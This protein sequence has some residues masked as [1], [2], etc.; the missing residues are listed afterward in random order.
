VKDTLKKMYKGK[1]E[2]KAVSEMV[3]Y[4]ILISIAMGV[5]VGVYAMIRVY[6]NWINESINCKDG[7]SI[8]I[9]SHTCTPNPGGKIT[10]KIKNNGRFNVDG[11][12]VSVGNDSKKVP[13]TYLKPD[14]GTYGHHGFSPNL[15]PGESEF[16]DF[17][18]LTGPPTKT[19]TE[20]AGILFSDSEIKIIQVQPYIFYKNKKVVCEN[21]RFTDDTINDCPVGTP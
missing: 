16:V 7:T 5:A 13:T 20:F 1:K 9:D 19:T 2:K 8:T 18:Y 10:F 12:I 3:A 21:V 4:I 6:P 11:I 14:A 17:Y 15:K